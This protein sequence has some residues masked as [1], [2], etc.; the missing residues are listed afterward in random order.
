MFTSKLAKDNQSCLCDEERLVSEQTSKG[1]V[2]ALIREGPHWG[3][4]VAGCPRS[5]NKP[6]VPSLIVRSSDEHRHGFGKEF[7]EKGERNRLILD[8]LCVLDT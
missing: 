2:E 5:A 4:D 3:K 8:R 7:R 6:R 1:T